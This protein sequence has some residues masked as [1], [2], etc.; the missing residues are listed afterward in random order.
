MEVMS[1]SG[2]LGV[3]TVRVLSLV[4]RMAPGIH[5]VEEKYCSSRSAQ[6]MERQQGTPPREWKV[7]C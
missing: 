5:S 1:Q 6:V 3:M 4:V 7:S 2:K